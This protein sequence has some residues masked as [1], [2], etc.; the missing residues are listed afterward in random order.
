MN[1][2]LSEEQEMLRKM[3]RDFFVKELPKSLVREMVKDEKGYPSELWRKM[4]DLGWMGLIL[5]D[6]YNGL[7]MSF[8]DLVILLE[9]MGRACLPG[10]FFST[11][12]L[13][14]LPVLKA[15][16]EEQKREILP[17]VASGDLIL[18]LA[19]TEPSAKYTPDGITLKVSRDKGGYVINGIKL[20][21]PDAH[22]ADKMVVVTRTRKSSSPEEGIT[23]FLVDNHSPGISCNKLVT[24]AGDKQC[25]VVFDKVKVGEKNMLG[26]PS[27]GWEYIAELLPKAAVAKCAEMVGIAQQALELAVSYSKERVQFD[28]PIGS[29][30]ILQHYMADMAIYVDGCRFI[31]YEAAWMMSQ[32]LPYSKQAAVA[33]AWVSKACLKITSL[34]HQVHGTISF[35]DDH[36]MALYTKRAK[37]AELAFGDDHF[38]LETIAQGMGL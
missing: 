21:V 6:K 10:P 30:Q 20:F 5:P 2:S 8:L 35:T 22:V 4:A 9:E 3:A 13:G 16:D 14:S 11:V 34:A 38:H 15:G 32:G 12:I 36:D 37:E 24:M 23:L 25:E 33:K 19:L 28:R 1:F 17:K 18:T 26:E 31:T 29:F 7:G 27:K